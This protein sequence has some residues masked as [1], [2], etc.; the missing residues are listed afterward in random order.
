[1]HP[2]G[3][4]RTRDFNLPPRMARKGASFYHTG[5]LID[6]KRKW[7]PLGNDVSR[8]LLEWARLERVESPRTIA[9][10]IARHLAAVDV[11][12]STRK[13]YQDYAA[14]I[15]AEFP[16]RAADSVT[17]G[18]IAE[19]FDRSPHKAMM[20]CVLTFL[21][22]A[23]DRM[24]RYE[25][26]DTNP[27]RGAWEF[28]SKPRGRYLEDAEFQ[29]IRGA[30][31]EHVRAAMDIAYLTGARVSDVAKLHHADVRDEGLYVQQKKTGAKQLFVWNDAL[32][33]A[34]A[35]AQAIPRPVR[36][37]YLFPGQRNGPMRPATLSVAFSKAARTLGIPDVRF[38]DIRGKAGT[39]AN[40]G[41]ISHQALLGHTTQAQSDDY[42]KR[43]ATPRVQALR[44]AL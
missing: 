36:C 7:T 25:W 6:G 5:Q 10:G 2:V 20:H 43:R 15:C 26:I 13:L 37:L 30:V 31:P 41:G 11:R 14:R 34:V 24:V 42:V 21:A 22:A 12:D 44:K 1:M 28:K 23:F 35:R 3:R 40:A 18:E 4:R 39:D 33:A 27:A 19:W 38:H 32:R 29:A 9:D 17:R 16:D 8:A